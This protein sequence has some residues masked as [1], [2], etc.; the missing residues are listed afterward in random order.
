LHQPPWS[1]G[2][3]SQT[4]GTL[5]DAVA[6]SCILNGV[7]PPDAGGGV[8]VELHF[9]NV[10]GGGAALREQG[11]LAHVFPELDGVFP[12]LHLLLLLDPVLR[13]G[14]PVVDARA[15][16]DALL[17]LVRALG[18]MFL[19]R[20]SWVCLKGGEKTN[21]PTINAV[22]SNNKM[23]A[24]HIE[25]APLNEV[26]AILQHAASHV[27]KLSLNLPV[28]YRLIRVKRAHVPT[29][30]VVLQRAPVPLQRLP[31]QACR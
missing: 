18:V 3:D 8:E 22:H 16:L 2:F 1:F 5:H 20:R 11:A 13:L 6:Q 19:W 28:Q 29:A 24:P 12:R 4:R 9:E 27:N 26:D 15:A 30:R 25:L 31:R 10:V 21:I 7:V 14:R 17:V 23:D